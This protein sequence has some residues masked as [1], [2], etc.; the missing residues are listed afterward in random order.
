MNQRT[1]LALALALFTLPLALPAATSIDATDAHA[2]GANIGWT[3]LRGDATNGAVIGEFICSGS[4]YSANCGWI[5]LG[6]GAPSN[7]VRYQ[8]LTAGDFGVNTQGYS[9]SGGTVEAKLRGYAY[10]ANI[11]WVNFEA[12]GDPRVDL[13]TGRLKGY[14]WGANI[15][16]IALDGTGVTVT[17]TAIVAGADTDG[18]SIADAWERLYAGNLTTMTGLTDSDGDGVLDR[19]EYGADTNPFDGSEALRITAFVPPRQLVVGGPYVTDLT[20]TSQPSRRYTIELVSDL[21]GTWTPQVA[22]LA[23]DAGATTFSSFVDS[24]GTKRFYRIRA[25]LPLAP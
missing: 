21:G 9:S 25:K 10:G 12:T 16:W 14:A 24:A 7:G 13:S 11:G 23:P 20:W 17:T 15:G 3:N 1:H 5:S 8:N 6:N 22:N 19:L 18:D 2:Y 4:I